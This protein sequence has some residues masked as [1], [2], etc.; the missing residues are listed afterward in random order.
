MNRTT[1]LLGVIVCA[2]LLASLA[3]PVLA[4]APSAYDLLSRHP[5]SLLNDSTAQKNSEHLGKGDIDYP[6]HDPILTM[7]Q[8]RLRIANNLTSFLEEKGYSVDNLRSAV[9]NAETAL[10][11]SNITAYRAAART[12]MLN[13]ESDIKNGTI[14]RDAVAEYIRWGHQTNH[15]F[16]IRIRNS[17]RFI[18]SLATIPRWIAHDVIP[19]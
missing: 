10:Q 15:P 5:R 13:L 12:F 19:G 14:D 8:S 11:N 4:L 7:L 9:R 16:Q 1:K 18:H 17:P 2:A 6:G 3:A